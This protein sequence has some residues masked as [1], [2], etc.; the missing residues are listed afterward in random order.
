MAIVL[1]TVTLPEDLVWIDRTDWSAT[2]GSMRLTMGGRPIVWTAS[3]NDRPMTLGGDNAWAAY[4]TVLALMALVAETGSMSL[5]LHGTAYTV[6]WR[7]WEPPV[8]EASPLV[9]V[10]DPQATDWWIIT[11]IKLMVV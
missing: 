7:H 1:E 11:G 10:P 8:I 4:S 5:T 6:R 9:P 2:A 3:R